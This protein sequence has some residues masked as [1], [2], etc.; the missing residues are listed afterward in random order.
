MIR[1]ALMISRMIFTRFA[2]ILVVLTLFV[3]SLEVVAYSKEILALN[4]GGSGNALSYILLRSPGVMVTYLPMS[5][6]IAVLLSLTELSYRNELTAIW[7]SGVSPARLTMMLVPVALLAGGI[8]FALQDRAIPAAAPTLH[9]WGIGD[10]GEKK[11]KIGERDPLWLRSGNDIMRAARA[12]DDSRK[13]EDVVIFRRDDKGLLTHQVFAETAERKDGIWHLSNVT[14]YS[15]KNEP[16]VHMESGTYG[17]T[18]RPAHAGARSGDPEEMTLGGLSYFVANEGFGIRPAYVYQTWW[19]K[20]LTPLL[21]SLVMMALCVPLASRFRR[22][23]GLG[24]LFAVGVG[25]GFVFFVLD[26]ISMSMGELG[27]APPWMAAWTPLAVFALLAVI[28]TLRT[29]RV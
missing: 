1:L 6:L 22:G 27:F 24:V 12:S 2:V 20:R 17:G 10:Y 8:Q 18:M 15:N 23:G 14:T 11:L 7:A 25:L 16:P 29:E 28:M 4:K 19:Q 26:G 21:V 3:L 13:L 9:D 5:F